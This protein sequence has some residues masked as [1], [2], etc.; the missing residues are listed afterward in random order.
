[1]TL[2]IAIAALTSSASAQTGETLPEIDT[3]YNFNP[4]LRVQFQV[5]ETRE[6]GD[7]TT[8]EIGP[9]LQFYLKKLSKLYEITSFDLDKSKSQLVLFSIGYRILPTPN[10]DPTNR[11]E[12]YVILNLPSPGKLLLSD[13]NRADLDWQNGTFSWHYRNLINVERP[14]TIRNYHP[15]PYLSAELWY[16][17]QYQKW[18]TTSLFAGCLF[19]FGKHVEFN[20]Y[21]EHQNNTGKSPNQRLNQLGLMLNLWFGKD[22]D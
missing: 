18:S 10:Q 5:K 4:D 16:T 6:G 7:P 20:P 15:S 19:P 1:M 13:R 14:L 11:L 22:R 17:S 12:P 9:S 8:A 3:Y 21:Y 2:A